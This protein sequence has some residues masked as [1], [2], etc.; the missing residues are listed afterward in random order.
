MHQ[1]TSGNPEVQMAWP[2]PTT[3]WTTFKQCNYRFHVWLHGV[4][5]IWLKSSMYV[6]M[7]IQS[8]CEQSGLISQITCRDRHLVVA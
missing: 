7:C 8:W 1:G 6:Y 3:N 4:P 2:I 5:F